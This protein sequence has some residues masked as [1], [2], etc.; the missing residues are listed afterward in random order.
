MSQEHKDQWVIDADGTGKIS[1]PTCKLE[2]NGF[3]GEGVEFSDV[4][5]VAKTLME[6]ACE[7]ASGAEVKSSPTKAKRKR[8]KVRN[9]FVP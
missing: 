6:M 4:L 1:H 8:A 3:I 9:P 5:Q 7:M 2:V